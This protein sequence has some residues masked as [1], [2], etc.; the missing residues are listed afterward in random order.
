MICST[1]RMPGSPLTGDRGYGVRALASAAW[2]DARQE[3]VVCV[4]PEMFTSFEPD[5]LCSCSVSCWRSG[6]AW[7]LMYF[8]FGRVIRVDRPARR[9]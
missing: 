8:D 3:T 4:A 7:A 1:R 5:E 2:S 9:R 6:S